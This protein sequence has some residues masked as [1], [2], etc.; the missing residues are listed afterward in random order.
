MAGGS[1]DVGWAARWS[2]VT[3]VDDEDEDSTRICMSRLPY[4]PGGRASCA[5]GSRCDA[6]RQARVTRL[7]VCE[8]IPL[9]T[10]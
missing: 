6:S 8:G 10:G 5:R 4:V 2:E 7:V 1:T 9:C 3:C